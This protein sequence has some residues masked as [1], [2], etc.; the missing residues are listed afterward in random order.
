MGVFK[1]FFKKLFSSES[2][3]KMTDAVADA[4]IVTGKALA[5]AELQKALDKL[6]ENATGI[7]DPERRAAVMA[8]IA[9]LR[10]AL[11]AYVEAIGAGGE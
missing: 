7:G 3:E 8:G 2:V 9:S 6:V 11:T 1:K 4:A 10:L 5:E